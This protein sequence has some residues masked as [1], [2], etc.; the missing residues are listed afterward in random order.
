MG[1]E[2]HAGRGPSAGAWG[3][4]WQSRLTWLMSHGVTNLSPASVRGRAGPGCTNL[5]VFTAPLNLH[6]K[7]QTDE[8]SKKKATTDLMGWFL[9]VFI[10]PTWL[11]INCI[12]RVIAAQKEYGYPGGSP[13]CCPIP[14]TPAWLAF[15]PP[16]VLSSLCISLNIEAVFNCI[17]FLY[18]VL[19]V[20]CCKKCSYTSVPQA[21]PGDIN[22]ELQKIQSQIPLIFCCLAGFGITALV[23][24][25]QPKSQNAQP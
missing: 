17:A 8:E 21:I 2:L 23:C 19:E 11:K 3:Q 6:Q 1:E 5:G 13:T 12:S 7:V 4:G 24:P 22:Q 20:L 9:T 25:I 16:G 15:K 18:T 10:K 14:Q